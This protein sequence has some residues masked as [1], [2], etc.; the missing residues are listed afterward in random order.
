MALESL[1][2]GPLVDEVPPPSQWSDGPSTHSAE[3][4]FQDFGRNLARADERANEPPTA[5][6]AEWTWSRNDSN[7]DLGYDDGFGL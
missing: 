7:H 3:A 4:W 6:V 1:S 5:P 2:S